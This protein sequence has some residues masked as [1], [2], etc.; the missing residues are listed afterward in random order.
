MPSPHPSHALLET[1]ARRVRR[2][3][4]ER[5]WTRDRLAQRSG[6]SVRYLAR[7]EAGDGNISLLRLQSLAD[8]L[9]TTAH[10]LVI[11][12]DDPH[13]RV[14]LV[15]LRG[16]G[17]SSVGPR[18]ARRLGVR[19][20]EMDALIVDACGLPLD[21]LFELHGEAYYR[22]LERDVLQRLISAPEPL[23]LAAAGGIV[24]DPV[25]WRMLREQTTVVWLRAKPE[26]HWERVVGQGDQRPMADNPD[27]MEELRSLWSA[28]EKIYAQAA[29]TIDTSGQT[30]AEAASRAERYLRPRN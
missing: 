28:R 19:F 22:R 5:S 17:K 6:L 11:V 7:V 24:N 25:T 4:H 12:E 18:L 15:G 8:A 27:A 1:L 26:Q 20:V 3:R 13:R 29:L 21:Q 16:A 30:A 2:L 9:G 14:A 10:A 23:V